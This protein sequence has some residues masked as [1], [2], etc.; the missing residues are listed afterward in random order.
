MAYRLTYV[1]TMSWIGPGQGPSGTTVG[2]APGPGDGNA[3]SL[4]AFNSGGTN[5]ASWGQNIVGSGTGGIIQ[6]ADITTITN[7]MAAD[8]A[9]QLNTASALAVMQGWPS[10][11]P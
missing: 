10:G 11:K 1:W 6:S 9:A 5:Q 7:G 4:S 2:A 3:Q 8:V